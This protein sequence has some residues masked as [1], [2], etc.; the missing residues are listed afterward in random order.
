MTFG[1]K[2]TVLF[3][4]PK[5]IYNVNGDLMDGFLLVDKPEGMT[6]RDVVTFVKNKL[7]IDKI[8]HTGTL[9]PFATGLLILCLG[10]ATKLSD[11]MMHMDKVYEGTIVFG[12]HFDTYD[13][14]GKEIEA[15][16]PNFEA[17]ALHRAI[18]EMVTTYQQQP[19]IFSA[20]K[21]GGIK[22][23]KAARKGHQ[24]DLDQ[25]EVVIHRFEAT[26][27]YQNQSIDF[28]T[29]VSKGTYV[30][31]M[32]VDLAA[33]LDTYGALSRLRRLKIGPYD[34]KDAQPMADVTS[35][36]LMDLT[37]F[38]EGFPSITLND[39]MISLVKNGV[40]LDERQHI[41]S[42]PFVIKDALGEMI[43]FYDHYKPGKY[44]PVVILKE[45][46]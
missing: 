45:P 18:Q 36:D 6:S 14:T 39:Y 16:Q 9:D 43:A 38:L 32:A 27:S 2:H 7:G 13:T 24:I 1:K 37:T 33:K 29:E 26:S 20:I 30:R 41:T 17:K 8:G 28:I 3:F 4:M 42:A 35:S 22:A 23:Y 25:R 46:R 15:A 10:K 34:I 40:V 11:Y 19:P 5:I 31:S 21:K 44:K 12:K